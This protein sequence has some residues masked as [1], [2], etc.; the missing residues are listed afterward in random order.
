MGQRSLQ[1]ARAQRPG[2]HRAVLQVDCGDQRFR[3]LTSFASRNKS[4][5]NAQRK[6]GSKANTTK[7]LPGDRGNNVERNGKAVVSIRASC[8][9]PQYL[10]WVSRQLAEAIVLRMIEANDRPGHLLQA[11]LQHVRLWKWAWRELA[12]VWA[13]EV[14]EVEYRQPLIER[15][16]WGRRHGVGLG[17]VGGVI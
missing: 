4:K 15:G 7:L 10:P 6:D 2:R 16:G 12:R 1:K 9:P 14:P 5:G 13:Q 17:F 3:T 8:N 11:I